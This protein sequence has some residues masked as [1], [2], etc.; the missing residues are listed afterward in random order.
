MWFNVAQNKH[1][2]WYIVIKYLN[3]RFILNIV[4]C[5]DSMFSQNPKIDL[6]S[7]MSQPSTSFSRLL[8]PRIFPHHLPEAFLNLEKDM[9]V[10]LSFCMSK[11]VNDNDDGNKF[12]HYELLIVVWDF[13]SHTH[14]IGFLLLM[15]PPNKRIYAV[16]N[17]HWCN[18]SGKNPK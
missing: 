14:I 15:Y 11:C 17:L 8:L 13:M 3:I 4:L 7:A 12:K 2:D 10:E 16:W 18:K 6:F 1:L 5:I 9:L